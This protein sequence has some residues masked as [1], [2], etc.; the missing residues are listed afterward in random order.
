MRY[1]LKYFLECK[2]KSQKQFFYLWLIKG[3]EH[4]YEYFTN[5]DFYTRKA[6]KDRM[7]GSW[8]DK[9]ESS[10][11]SGDLQQLHSQVETHSSLE[12]I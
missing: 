7:K 3:L 4:Y 11:S 10:S 8:A 1:Y 2:K 9:E 12:N 5:F 6:R